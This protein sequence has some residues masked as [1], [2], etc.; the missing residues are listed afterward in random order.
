MMMVTMTK[1]QP[2]KK[3]PRHLRD[4]FKNQ[5]SIQQQKNTSKM[6]VIGFFLVVVPRKSCRVVCVY[7]ENKCIGEILSFCRRCVFGLYIF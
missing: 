6:S 7:L 5:C 4:F 2:K 1:S 3:S